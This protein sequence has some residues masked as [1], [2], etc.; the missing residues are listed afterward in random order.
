MSMSWFTGAMTI[1]SAN[2]QPQSTHGNILVLMSSALMDLSALLSVTTTPK[3]PIIHRIPS[4]QYNAAK[5]IFIIKELLKEHE[6]SSSP[7][8]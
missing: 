5:D 7:M 1:T 8:H 4:T 6:I 3:M 2:P